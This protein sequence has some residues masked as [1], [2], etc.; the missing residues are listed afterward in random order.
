MPRVAGV[1]KKCL[2]GGSVGLGGGGARSG[3]DEK[4]KTSS[5]GA[6]T[7]RGADK[8]CRLGWRQYLE[9]AAIRLRPQGPAMAPEESLD[10]VD[11]R[12][13]EYIKR[14]D[15]EEYPW[16]TAAAAAELGLSVTRVYQALQK[17]QRH[18]RSELF[19]YFKDGG[20]RIQTE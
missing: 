11:E 18:K 5:P 1:R 4:G 16:D 8:R 12:V 15:F 3:A 14:Y 7:E 20:L 13:F 17:L 9:E 6:R 2:F 10:E 19:L